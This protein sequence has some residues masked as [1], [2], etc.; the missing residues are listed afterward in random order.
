[1]PT[2]LIDLAHT[3]APPGAPEA[4]AH[5]VSVETRYAR[6]HIGVKGH[7]LNEPLAS[8]VQA[9]EVA[10]PLIAE[11]HDIKPDSDG[12][13]IEELRKLKLSISGAFDPWLNRQTTGTL[14]VGCYRLAGKTEANLGGAE[15]LMLQSDRGRDDPFLGER[16]PFDD[17]VCRETKRLAPTM[18]NSTICNAQEG[19]KVSGP[20]ASSAYSV[21]A[22]RWSGNALAGGSAAVGCLRNPAPVVC[23]RISQWSNGEE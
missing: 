11:H 13:G 23:P 3:C 6:P 10:T 18:A 4:L 15:H 20:R 9:V 19:R 2:A 7:P 1:M 5:V 14:L 12:V 17:L 8:K 16:D 21:T 22:K